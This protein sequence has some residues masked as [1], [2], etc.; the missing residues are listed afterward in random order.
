MPGGRMIWRKA[1]ARNFYRLV[2]RNWIWIFGISY[3]IPKSIST[4]YCIPLHVPIN[5]W[6]CI[7]SLIFLDFRV[8]DPLKTNRPCYTR[9]IP[10]G[11]FLESQGARTSG[12]LIVHSVPLMVP[13][14]MVFWACGNLKRAWGRGP[15]V[16]WRRVPW[17][18]SVLICKDDVFWCWWCRSLGCFL[19]N[20]FLLAVFVRHVE[21]GVSSAFQTFLLP[22]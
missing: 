13:M 1:A 8:L 14:A 2:C 11:T 17:R 12:T 10:S 21:D 9:C 19:A 22:I 18:L 3:P 6:K 15:G 4:K 5:V 16:C 7:E 20:A